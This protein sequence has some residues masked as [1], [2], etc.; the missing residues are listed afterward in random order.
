MQYLHDVFKSIDYLISPT[1]GLGYRLVN[2][3]TTTLTAEAA[4]GVVTE[5]NPG[6]D[7]SSSGA[8]TAAEKAMHKISGTATF[9]QSLSSL[10][11]TSDFEDVLVTF[12]AG[13]ATDI[14]SRAQLKVDF[15]DTFKNKPPTADVK[16]NDTA[17]LMSFVFKF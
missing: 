5:K 6:F 15:L 16:Q 12:Q 3:M 8:L 14:T 7:A 11:K 4:V 10:W 2:S 9:T 17:F 13:L 1:G